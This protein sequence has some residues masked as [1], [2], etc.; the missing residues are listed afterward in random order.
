MALLGEEAAALVAVA[1][2]GA[3][4]FENTLGFYT[5]A[6]GNFTVEQSIGRVLRLPTVYAFLV[7]VTLAASGCEPCSG[8]VELAGHVRGAFTVLGMMLVGLGLAS[9]KTTRIDWK[10][11][12]ATFIAKFFVWPCRH[13]PDSLGR[14]YVPALLHTTHAP[15]DVS[16]EH[17]PACCQHRRTRNRTES[18]TRESRDIGVLLYTV[19]PLLHS[20]DDDAVPVII[21]AVGA[22]IFP[23]WLSPHRML[24]VDSQ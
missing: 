5:V 21:C 19:R 2:L 13:G 23:K 14:Y 10:F 15:G 4:L 22:C 9:L 17:C 3:G 11:I 16:P 24:R 12:G 8:I 6:R 20:S 18:R 1:I 7:G